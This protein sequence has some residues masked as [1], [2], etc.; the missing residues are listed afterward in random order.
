MILALKLIWYNH[1]NILFAKILVFN[2]AID[3]NCHK[4]KKILITYLDGQIY[5]IKGAWAEFK[6]ITEK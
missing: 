3:E 6:H 1:K 2:G 5:Q 4:S